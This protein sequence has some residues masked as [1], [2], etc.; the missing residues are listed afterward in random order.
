MRL[1]DGYELKVVQHETAERKTY[2][3][4]NKRV[5]QERYSYLCIYGRMN[6]RPCNCGTY[7]YNHRTY[8]VIGYY[9]VI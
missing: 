8:N 7:K 3:A 9:P 6:L 2:Y 4:N 1:A 5:S